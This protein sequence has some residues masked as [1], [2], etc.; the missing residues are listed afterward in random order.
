MTVVNNPVV[1]KGQQ[2]PEAE[3]R[4]QRDRKVLGTGMLDALWTLFHYFVLLRQVLTVSAFPKD[5][6]NSKCLYQAAQAARTSRS[7]QTRLASA[8]SSCFLLFIPTCLYFSSICYS[9][10]NFLFFSSQLL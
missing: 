1:E 5:P 9:L 3:Q 6:S 7:R 4:P 8:A 2:M 10:L